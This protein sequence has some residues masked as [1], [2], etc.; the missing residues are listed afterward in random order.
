MQLTDQELL[1]FDQ[2]RL[3]DFKL[4]RAQSTL[5]GKHGDTYRVQLL[6]ALWID[7]WRERLMEDKESPTAHPAEWYDGAEFAFREI[8]AHL[9]QGDLLPGGILYEETDDGK[10]LPGAE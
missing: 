9:R 5:A 10:L 2:R 3:A 4:K 7:G 8:A 6:D 1:D